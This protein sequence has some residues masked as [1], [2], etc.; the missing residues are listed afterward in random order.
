MSITFSDDAYSFDS[1]SDDAASY[2]A[3]VLATQLMNAAS[4]P[5]GLPR[6][7]ATL[8]VVSA[9]RDAGYDDLLAGAEIELIGC[10]LE[11][12][13]PG[14][15]LEAFS[16]TLT[17][18]LHRPE[19][20]DSRQLE[21][22][23]R[24]YP[25]VIESACTHPDVPLSLLNHLL[26]GLQAFQDSLGPSSA[27]GDYLRHRMREALGNPASDRY[28]LDR[29]IDRITP[30]DHPALG[31]A[32]D[33]S[34]VELAWERHPEQALQVSWRMLTHE[35]PGPQKARL[36][37]VMLPGLIAT[38]AWQVA[39]EAH[40]VAYEY[41]REES[42]LSEISEHFRFL[43]VAGMWPRL[44]LLLERHLGLIRHTHDPW[45]LLV[46]M[47]AI[48]GALESLDWA[49][50]G[51]YSLKVSLA[52]TSRFHEIPALVHPTVAQAR[53]LLGQA[54]ATLAARYDERNGNVEVSSS[55]GL[56]DSHPLP[57]GL[58][59]QGTEGDARFM[60]RLLRARAL[61]ECNQ[62]FDALLLLG[63]L[64]QTNFPSVRRL[65]PEIRMLT[66]LAR[67]QMSHDSASAAESSAA[68]S[69]P[70]SQSA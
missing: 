42:R 6:T 69:H 35:L 64:E 22:L 8:D 25:E 10:Y 7:K 58:L 19:L 57:D 34:Q 63:G 59:L 44:L 27:A 60:A 37:R 68:G 48:I 38:D 55:L 24:Y 36:L 62:G 2:S 21:Q 4:I 23:A 12:R 65:G 26:A 17:R 11:G 28:F 47:R 39:W 30:A 41:D 29:A 45:D 51:R 61:L 31:R 66:S 67:M 53:D 20:Y 46:G 3:A 32:V 33:I 40:L 14:K 13:N 1:A 16:S 18:L 15:A 50:Y 49:G 70:E 5:P 56:L 9:A 43:G 54:A 52:P